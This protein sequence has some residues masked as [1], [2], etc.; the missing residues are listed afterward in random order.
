MHNYLSVKTADYTATTLTV[1]PQQTMTEAGERRQIV[2][3]FD[4]GSVDVVGVSD[5]SYF[6]VTLQWTYITEAECVTILDFWH[7][8]AKANGR[9]RTFYWEH[10]TDTKTY[11]VRFMSPLSK[12]YSPGLLQGITSCTLRVEGVKAS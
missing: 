12:T 11:V 6:T 4:D 8:V 7:N 2:H 10:P 1:T 3:E 9:K 5:Q